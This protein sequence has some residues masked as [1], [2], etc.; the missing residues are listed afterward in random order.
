MNMQNVK[1]LFSHRRAVDIFSVIV[2]GFIMAG[3]FLKVNLV[4]ELS[5]LFNGLMVLPNILAVVC[6]YKLVIKAA[7]DYDENFKAGKQPVFGPSNELTDKLTSEDV[8]AEEE[9]ENEPH[10]HSIPRRRVMPRRARHEASG[11][12]GKADTSSTQAKAPADED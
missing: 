12:Q 4:W 6:L 5:D 2:L 3:S 9:R 10:H 8:P 11:A 1:Y 7:V